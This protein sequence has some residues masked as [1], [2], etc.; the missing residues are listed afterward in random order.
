VLSTSYEVPAQAL[1]VPHHNSIDFNSPSNSYGPPPSGPAG[2]DVIGLESR[3][4]AVIVEPQ[5]L[6]EEKSADLPGL[7]SG[8][9]ST[10][11]DFIS[12]HKSHSLQ[13]PTNQGAIGNFQLQ[14]QGSHSEHNDNRVDGP[15]H[16]QILA[17]GLLQSILTAIEQKPAQ[18]VP[19][20]TENDEEHDHK[21]AQTFL[22]SREGQH[23]LADKSDA[24]AKDV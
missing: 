1:E 9:S 7:S 20:V 4:N 24:N 12:A 21:D 16:Q 15:D 3:A 14:I 17:D 18:T 19:Q 23:V 6:H 5:T 2:L 13:V 8:L 22:K 11:L 10:G